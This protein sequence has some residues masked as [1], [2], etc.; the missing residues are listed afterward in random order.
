MGRLERFC[1]IILVITVPIIL[2]TLSQNIIFRV[3]DV[4]AYYFN[5]SQVVDKLYTSVTNAEMADGIASF[6]NHLSETEFQ[7]YEDTGYEQLGI[8]CSGDSYNMLMLRHALTASGVMC[9][10][11]LLIT[12]AIYGYFIKRNNKKPLRISFIISMILTLAL[13]ALET[14]TFSIETMREGFFRLIG[15]RTASS[16]AEFLT[17]MDDGFW[18]MISVFLGGMTLIMILLAVY[19]HFSVTRKTKMFYN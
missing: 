18:A 10:V 1:S 7:I 15:V 11:G 16:S 6:L 3:P 14:C 4:Y 9:I 17:I 2:I 13:F 19:I 12:I 5:D 8:F